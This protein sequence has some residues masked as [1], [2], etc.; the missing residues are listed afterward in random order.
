MKR[1]AKKTK[2]KAGNLLRADRIQSEAEHIHPFLCHPARRGEEGSGFATQRIYACGSGQKIKQKKKK[3]PT[4]TEQNITENK[5]ENSSGFLK[6][7]ICFT[8]ICLCIFF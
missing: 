5:R 2:K 1:K 7:N 6:E 8:I 3:V 4:T